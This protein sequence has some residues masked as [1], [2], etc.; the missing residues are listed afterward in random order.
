MVSGPAEWIAI[1]L[2]PS[3][4]SEQTVTALRSIV[5]RGVVKILD[6]VI[7]RRSAEGEVTAAEF[8]AGD[9]AE[10]FEALDGIVLELLSDQDIADIGSGLPDDSSA[11]LIVWENLWATEFA[12]AV[13]DAGGVL[14]ASDRIP[15]AV[16]ELALDGTSDLNGA[17]Q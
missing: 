1:G 11:L 10:I 8:D 15:A 16:F 5:D 13:R 7:I 2:P 3:G 14:L 4:V 17:S 9:G 6:L 12:D